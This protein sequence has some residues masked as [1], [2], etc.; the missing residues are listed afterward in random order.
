MLPTLESLAASSRALAAAS[1][2][3]SIS[4]C[5]AVDMLSDDEDEEIDAIRFQPV[6]RRTAALDGATIIDT[7]FVENPSTGSMLR[8]AKPQAK[9]KM[10]FDDR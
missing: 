4:S 8:N 7:E 6:F 1:R 2:S 5:C 10:K 3:L 9:H